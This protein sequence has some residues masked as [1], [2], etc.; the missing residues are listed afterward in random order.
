MT[1]IPSGTIDAPSRPVTGGIIPNSRLARE[2]TEWVNDTET[3]L[4]FHHSSRVYCWGAL[5]GERRGVCIDPELLYVGAMFNDMGLTPQ[6][7]SA[8]KRFEVDGANVARDFLRSHCIAE[9]DIETVRTAIALRTTP[10]IP[11]FMHLVIALV[12]ASVEIDVLGVAFSE[13]TEAERP[14]VVHAH[15]RAARFKEEIIQAF[16]DAIHPRPGTTF[17]NVKADLLADKDP[18]LRPE[19][20]CRVIRASACPAT[21]R[22]SART[23][24]PLKSPKPLWM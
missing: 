4:P 1:L 14:V 18:S 2:V 5:S 23:I 13:S 21:P 11:Q 15:L 3:P 8:D 12:T 20:F 19:N 16:Y 7:A 9:R 17:G 10:G 22:Q 24:G 6:Y